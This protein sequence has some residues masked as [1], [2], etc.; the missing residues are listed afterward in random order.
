MV[1]QMTNLLIVFNLIILVP[2][3]AVVR[4]LK[5]SGKLNDNRLALIL[6]GYF[7]FSFITTSLPLGTLNAHVAL[8]ADAIFLLIIWIIGYP[9]ICWLYQKFDSRNNP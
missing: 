4:R 5:T 8:I 2:L 6:N 1:K 7:S 3:E 9:W